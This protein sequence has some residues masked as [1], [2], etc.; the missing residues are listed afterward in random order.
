MAP[1]IIA[2]IMA[3]AFAGYSGFRNSGGGGAG[4]GG[5]GGGGGRPSEARAPA[6]SGKLG[7]C[8]V[9]VQMR[10]RRCCRCG[11]TKERGI[12][13]R[14]DYDCQFVSMINDYRF[15]KLINDCEIMNY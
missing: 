12:I 8:T 14:L 1:Q 13:I 2:E 11:E 5:G 6:P 9:A 7:G 15:T 4:G 3:K 10:A